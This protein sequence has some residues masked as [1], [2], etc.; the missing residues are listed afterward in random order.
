EKAFTIMSGE[1]NQERLFIRYITHRVEISDQHI[2]IEMCPDHLLEA[3]QDAM[4]K[5]RE[6][7]PEHPIILNKKIKIAAANNGSKV[8]IG[9]S[10]AG[11]NMQLVKAIARSFL[12]NEQLLKSERASL[13]DI[14]NHEKISSSTYVSKIVRLRFLAPDIIESIL[15]GSN[16]ADW[17]VEKLFKVKT[18]DWNEQRQ[19]LGLA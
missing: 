14:G 12:W 2:Q 11:R 9:S 18:L 5:K 8:I 16:P 1:A 4:H 3:L 19:A 6:V 7:Q 15:N 13:Q 10:Q 17:T